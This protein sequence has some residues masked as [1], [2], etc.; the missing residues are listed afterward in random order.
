MCHAKLRDE[1]QIFVCLP[2]SITTHEPLPLS[3]P[4]ICQL[5]LRAFAEHTPETVPLSLIHGTTLFDS[6]F[7]STDKNKAISLFGWVRTHP[8]RT[9]F[10]VSQLTPIH[11]VAPSGLM[12]MAAPNELGMCGQL[13]LTS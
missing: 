7:R 3:S 9:R 12:M 8:Q 6:P 5:F 1:F 13:V 4:C 10:S 11:Q 2:T